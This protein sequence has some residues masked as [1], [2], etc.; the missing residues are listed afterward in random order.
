VKPG[1]AWPV[2]KALV[3]PGGSATVGQGR[4]RAWR[5]RGGAAVV[6][7][8]WAGQSGAPPGLGGARE[9]VRGALG[10]SD[11]ACGSN[12]RERSR[13][14]KGRGHVLYPLM[15]V[16][17][18]HQPTNISRLAYVAAVVPY[19]V[20]YVGLETDERNLKYQRWP[21]RI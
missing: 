16:G 14:K 9:A 2:G 12:A 10:G 20:T 19:V 4:G 18:T 1:R 11:G 15:F 13:K 6:G 17:L 5:D 3:G 8:G 21:R 7:W